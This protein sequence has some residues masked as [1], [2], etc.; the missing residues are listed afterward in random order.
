[1]YLSGVPN[2]LREEAFGVSISIS[3]VMLVVLALGQMIPLVLNFEALFFTNQNRRTFWRRSGRWLEANEVLVRF[4]TM[5]AFLLQ[6]RLLQTVLSACSANG[7]QKASSWSA[8]KKTLFV[9]LLLYISGGLIA[10]LVN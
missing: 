3:L 1:M 9:S 8:K 5:F 4:M 2:L 6:I 10:L 7:N